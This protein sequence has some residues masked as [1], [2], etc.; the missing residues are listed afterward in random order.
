M[1]NKNKGLMVVIAILIVAVVGLLCYIGYDKIIAGNNNGQV[2]NAK[3]VKNSAI[4]KDYPISDINSISTQNI[5]SIGLGEVYGT[6]SI[7]SDYIENHIKYIL[8]DNIKVKHEDYLCKLD[9]IPFYKYENGYFYA[10][11]SYRPKKG[12]TRCKYPESYV[13]KFFKG[14]SIIIY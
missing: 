5:L 10:K 12:G 7:S 9:N 1:E 14:T 6:Y 3:D 13:E 2:I 4:C 8:G 11:D